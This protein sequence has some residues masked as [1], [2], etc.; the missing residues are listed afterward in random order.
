MKAGGKP[1]TRAAAD[2]GERVKAGGHPE[3]RT[4]WPRRTRQ[5]GR[6]VAE[7][8]LRAASGAQLSSDSD[9]VAA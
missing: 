2:A 4:V 7:G 6:K 9:E 3:T 1:E 8:A 5:H